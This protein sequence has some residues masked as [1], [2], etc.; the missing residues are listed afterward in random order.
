[1]CSS[2]LIADDRELRRGGVSYTCDTVLE[3]EALYGKST[4]IFLIIGEDLVAEFYKWHNADFLIKRC[5]IIVARRPQNDKENFDD[6]NKFNET[7]YNKN[8]SSKSIFPH[9]SV[10]NPQFDISSTEIRDKIKQNLD[11]ALWKSLV[12]C[13]VSRYIMENKLYGYKN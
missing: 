12:P 4:E 6:F 2:D 10:K 9:I 11:S 13:G 3:I 7:D 1:M 5:K 8:F